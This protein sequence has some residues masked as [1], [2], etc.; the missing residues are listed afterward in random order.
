MVRA[1]CCHVTLVYAILYL[2]FLF[3][4]FSSLIV[5]SCTDKSDRQVDDTRMC[6]LIHFIF[7]F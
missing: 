1:A 5:K 3:V 7:Y 6:S 4:P 2:L